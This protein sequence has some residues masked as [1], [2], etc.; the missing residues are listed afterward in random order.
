MMPICPRI[1]RWLI[2]WSCRLSTP[3]KRLAWC[4]SRLWRAVFRYWQV[5]CPEFGRL[6][7]KAGSRFLREMLKNWQNKC[8]HISAMRSIATS[9]KNE[10]VLSRKPPTRG[11]GLFNL[12][13]RIIRN[14]W[15][16]KPYDRIFSHTRRGSGRQRRRPYVWFSYP[17]YHYE[18]G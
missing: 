12:S 7:K 11:L 18:F 1:T 8:K 15:N 16:E 17:Q 6:R 5:I 9:G 3:A 4:C 2:C 10:R 13:T 14:W